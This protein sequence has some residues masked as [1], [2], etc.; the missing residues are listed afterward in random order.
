MKPMTMAALARLY[1]PDYSAC[2]ARKK[3]IE[4]IAVNPLLA[5]ELSG[6]GFEHRGFFFTPRQLDLLF[7]QLGEP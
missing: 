7:E 6:C 5:K 2:W 3:M 4:M 1:F